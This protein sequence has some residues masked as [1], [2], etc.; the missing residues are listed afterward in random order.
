MKGESRT[1]LAAPDR[2]ASASR[3]ADQEAD[4]PAVNE[5]FGSAPARDLCALR[6]PSASGFDAG[7]RGALHGG[8]EEAWWRPLSRCFTWA[9]T[10]R[11]VSAI[12]A[13]AKY[14]L[15]ARLLTPYDFGV[16]TIAFLSLE[17]LSR[18]T[19]PCFEMAL[20]QQEEEIEPFLDTVWIISL[21]QGVVIAAILIIAARP[22]AIFFRQADG[23]GVF[24]AVAPLAVL[25]AAQSPG[26]VALYRRME[27]HIVLVLNGAE[28][29]GNVAFG[30]PAILFWRDWRGLVAAVIAGQS[31][32][33]LL[34][35]WYFPYRP[36]LRFEIARAM[37]LFRFGRW[38]SGTMIAE[39]AA[40]QVDNFA[41]AHLLGPRA[42]GNYQMAFRMGEMPATELAFA[43]TIVTMPTVAKLKRR[44]E[45]CRRLFF[46]VVSVVCIAGL[47]YA[48]VVLTLG[49]RLVEE[50]LGAKWLGAMS[51][52][53]V[54]SFYGLFQ[55]VLILSKSFFDG[56]GSPA[57]SFRMTLLRALTLL[58]LIYPLTNRYGT[59]GAAMAALA[60]VGVPLPFLPWF[61][62]RSEAAALRRELEPDE[63][64]LSR[65]AE[66]LPRTQTE[67]AVEA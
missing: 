24:Y 35:Y 46:A 9:G 41:V 59:S 6:G 62:R 43:A 50:A 44:P 65:A 33:T 45:K 30:I 8:P 15:F 54:L 60:S 34:T 39:F 4:R 58:A 3:C 20:V 12:G 57:S 47:A 40:Q 17:T 13:I 56:F 2:F 48:C 23:Y 19:D 31:A 51:A 28:L 16:T 18:L 53:R 36:G 1:K 66:G 38:V 22:V 14:V 42:V 26:W 29:V 10:G 67:S 55:G 63:M 7:E 32:R 52:L 61:Y 5:L 37:K 25:Q 21:I 64:P 11:A 49:R 27:F